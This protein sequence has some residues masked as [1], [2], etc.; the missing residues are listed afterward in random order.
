MATTTRRA[1]LQAPAVLLQSKKPKGLHT[2][3]EL[4]PGE[5]ATVPLSRG[6]PARVELLELAEHRDALRGA[7]RQAR[8]RVRVNG[9]EAWLVSGNYR[10]PVRVGGVQIDCPA[11]RGLERNSTL[12]LWRLTAAVRLRLWPEDSPW[13]EP[14]TFQL[15]LRSRWLHTDTQATN[16][17]TFVNGGDCPSSPTIYYHNDLDFG[18]AEG[19]EPVFAAT[20]ALVVS[21]RNEVHP[22]YKNSPARPRP[23]VLYLVDDRGWFYRYSHFQSIDPEIRLGMRVSMG[24]RLG[25]LGKEGGAGWSHLHFG[26]QSLQPS[27]QW[28]TEDAWPF[29]WQA[30]LAEQKP[31]AIAV[32]RP[33]H[34]A[35]AGEEVELDG[36][37]SWSAAGRIRRYEWTLS[38]GARA[39]GPRARRRYDKPGSYSE[40]LKITD[41][42]GNTSWDFAVV[43]VLDPGIVPPQNGKRPPFEAW[44]PTIHALYWP[45]TGVRPGQPVLF[46]VCTFRSREHEETWDFGD[47]SPTVKVRSEPTAGLI[48]AAEKYGETRH[49]F[50]RP[51]DYIV[52]VVSKNARGEAATAH[53]RVPVRA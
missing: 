36:S 33:H 12:S 17:P 49:A 46:R 31:A 1:F 30:C 48:L 14:G 2:P 44:P 11:T 20:E 29:V 52:R 6:K 37:L 27:G 41:A 3:V 9:E 34:L 7:L 16:E 45:T 38:S 18:G 5:S 32:A 21:A 23:D 53:L 19:L 40:I 42:A 15:P 8:V 39:E 10:L 26:I 25:L 28:A 50:R 22:D 51:G 13:I 35:R 43:Q 47:G 24:Q 4:N